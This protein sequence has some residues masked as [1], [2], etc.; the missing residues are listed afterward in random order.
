M[1][2]RRGAT[3][4][5]RRISTDGSITAAPELEQGRPIKPALMAD[6]ARAQK[7]R[8]LAAETFAPEQIE[9]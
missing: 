7:L 1:L 3:L 5:G 6:P 9:P 2:I 8:T 4:E